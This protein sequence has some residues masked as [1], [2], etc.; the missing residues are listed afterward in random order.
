MA[1]FE[2]IK[3]KLQQNSFAHNILNDP[4]IDP[5]RINPNVELETRFT[6]TRPTRVQFLG[7]KG[8]VLYTRGFIWVRGLHPNP[9]E[10][11]RCPPLGS[12][13]LTCYQTPHNY[14]T[15]LNQQN[16]P[17][18][19]FIFFFHTLPFSTSLLSLLYCILTLLT[20]LCCFSEQPI[21]LSFQLIPLKPHF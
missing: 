5:T 1:H 6:R 3:K 19:I 15:P 10:P 17:S 21:S 7:R 8:Y 18:S 13:R 4:V 14:N 2:E 16:S 20:C 12:V 11:A 9:P